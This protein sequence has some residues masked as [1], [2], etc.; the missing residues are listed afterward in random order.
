M[1]IDPELLLNFPIPDIRQRVTPRDVAFYALSVGMAQDP[2][3]PRQLDFVDQH[4][5][6]H[7]LPWMALVLGH[8][9]FWLTDPRIG[10]DAVRL[11]HGEQALEQHLPLPVE[12]EIV[13]RTRVT[14][15]VDKGAGR[16]ALLY[17]EKQVLDAASGALYATA[18]STTF[19]RGDGGFGGPTGPVRRPPPVP[20][21]PPDFVVELPTRPEQALFYRLNGDD[22]PLHADP[23]WPR[24]PV[25]SGRSCMGCAPSAWSRMRC[26]GPSA[27]TMRPASASSSSAS[28]P[29]SCPA[30]RS[31]PRSGAMDRSAPAWPNAMS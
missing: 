27:I 18:R 30:R 13:G 23:P 25:S 3:D 9:G 12:G 16:G 14:G 4:R 11:V 5:Q 2:A 22:N 6:L 28:P 1:T 31:A 17:M 20:G 8:P 7:A 24:P 29:P 10:V 19:L 15:L 21:G 26:C